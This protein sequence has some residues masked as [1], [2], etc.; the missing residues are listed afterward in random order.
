MIYNVCLVPGE[1]TE[2]VMQYTGLKDKNGKEIYEGD[3]IESVFKSIDLLEGEGR[4]RW[5]V[6]WRDGGFCENDLRGDYL[7]DFQVGGVLP[8]ETVVG[9]IHENPELLK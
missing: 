9:N 3:I 1:S 6:E 4:T 2:N 8:D 5:I 7:A